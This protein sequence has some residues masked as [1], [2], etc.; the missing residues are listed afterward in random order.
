MRAFGSEP[1]RKATT[2]KTSSGR[3]ASATDTVIE[4]IAS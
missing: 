4:S 1:P 2:S 3:G